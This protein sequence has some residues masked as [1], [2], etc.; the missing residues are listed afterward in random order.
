MRR[1]SIL[2]LGG[3]SSVLSWGG[4]FTPAVWALVLAEVLLCLVDRLLD[5]R[6]LRGRGAQ[7]SGWGWHPTHPGPTRNG[8]PGMLTPTQSRRDPP[9]LPHLYGSL[10]GEIEVQGSGTMF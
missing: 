9:L 10:R 3:G 6:L 1:I 2:Y 8:P 7:D 4:G 5:R